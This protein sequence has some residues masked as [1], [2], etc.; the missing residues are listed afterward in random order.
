MLLN[1]IE[2]ADEKHEFILP[3]LNDIFGRISY[4]LEANSFKS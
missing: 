4:E 2:L 1:T 3:K